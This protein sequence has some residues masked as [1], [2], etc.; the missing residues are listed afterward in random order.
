MI[1]HLKDGQ[2]VCLLAAN[3][4]ALRLRQLLRQK[5]PGC[6]ITIYETA[7]PP[8]GGRLIGPAKVRAFARNFGPWFG[9]EPRIHV[10]HNFVISA[11]P[12]KD[13][14]VA[15]REILTLYP[16]HIPVKNVLVVALNS[17]HQL[18]HTP[19]VILNTGRIEGIKEDFIILRDGQTPSVQRVQAAIC[20][21]VGAMVGALGDKV[22]LSKAVP[23]NWVDIFINF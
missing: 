9:P 17:P 10:E 8:C 18:I 7:N 15:L 16:K 6:K 5:A 4:G 21:E 13:T 3:S 23:Q 14:N 11:L 19:L 1:P 20:D 2:V 12:A 22:M